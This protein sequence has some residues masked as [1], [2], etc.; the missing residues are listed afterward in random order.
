MNDLSSHA[1]RATANALP[2]HSIMLLLLWIYVYSAPASADD[3]IAE[4]SYDPKT[5]YS[6]YIPVGS[7]VHISLEEGEHFINVGA[8]ST[9]AIDVGAEGSQI[10]IKAQER[11][12]H[13][14]LTLMSDKRV[15]I[16]DYTAD[17]PKLTHNPASDTPKVLYSIRFTYPQS[18]AD[19]HSILPQTKAPQ[20]AVDLDSEA[21][22]HNSKLNTAISIKVPP[23]QNYDYWYKGPSAFKPLAV[24]D[25]GLH[26]SIL[27]N[28]NTPL[29][30]IYV[31]EDDG[32]QS[33]TNLH[34]AE[35]HLVLHRVAAHWLLKRGDTTAYIDN[36]SF[37]H[38]GQR[39]SSGTVDPMVTRVVKVGEQ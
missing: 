26:T 13:S 21:A 14:N 37:D 33:L 20:S 29:P 9:S 39:A 12:T 18:T 3:R 35:D 17:V 23:P 19:G 8:G 16:F 5:V 4:W 32:S 25:N 31:I 11:V 38:I 30:A 7:H 28:P 6:L 27:F 10:L 15:Y 1:Q 34:M 2:I 36:R 24:S 22:V